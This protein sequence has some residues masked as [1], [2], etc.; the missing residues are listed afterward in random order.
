MFCGLLSI[1]IQY[2]LLTLYVILNRYITIFFTTMHKFSQPRNTRLENTEV[3]CIHQVVN[4]GASINTSNLKLV[5][6][7]T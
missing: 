1:T 2:D 6:N 3:I 5:K 7:D 4:D